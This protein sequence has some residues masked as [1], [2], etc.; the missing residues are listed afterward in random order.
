M[1]TGEG[2]EVCG[3]WVGG[4]GCVGV[5]MCRCVGVCVVHVCVRVV[6]LLC[7]GVHCCRPCSKF[8]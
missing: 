7:A 2:G 1:R 3:W 5:W 4:C 6:S 8:S